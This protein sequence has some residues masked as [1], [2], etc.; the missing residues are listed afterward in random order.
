MFK[1]VIAEKPSVGI[2]IAN[3]L[4]ARKQKSGFYEGNGYIV[5]WCIGHL[6]GVSNAS[7]Y[8]P[9]Y[10]YWRYEHL[11]IIP[12]KWQN[13]LR[14]KTYQHFQLLKKTM[15]RKDV[16]EI[17]NACDAGREG[18]LIFR[19]AY[20]FAECNKPVKR[21]WISSMEDEAIRKG[22]ENLKPSEMYDNLYYS[23]DARAKADWLVGINFTRLFSVLYH[24]KLC[25]GRV[26]TPT[27]ALIISREA[28][29]TGFVP[30]TYYNAQITFG[31]LKATSKKISD[32]AE[33]EKIVAECSN[34]FATVISVN[35]EEKEEKAPLLY[36]LTTLQRD[37]N[38]IFGY[39]AQQ[40]LDYAQSLYEK[41]LCTYPRTDSRYLTEDMENT[42]EA[43]LK[44]SARLTSNDL[45]AHKYT[46]NKVCD[47][48]KVSDHH[49]II[50]TFTADKVDLF[51][52]NKEERNILRMIAL[53]LIC[54][55]AE[56]YVYCSKTAVLCCGNTEFEVKYR[57]I[58]KC[59]W[60]AF[61]KADGKGENGDEII[62]TNI[63]IGDIYE[64]NK[65]EVKKSKTK[66]KPHYTEDTLLSA[67]ENAGAAEALKDAE[68]KGLGTP[69]TRA[70]MIEKLVSAGYIERKQ[71]K[72][73][74]VLVPAK[75]GESLIFVVPEHIQS[76]LLT[77]EWEYRLKLIEKGELDADLFL[78]DIADMVT[79][80]CKNY[81]ISPD[82]D[83]LFPSGKE[84]V[85]TCPRCGGNVT[86]SKLGF[87]CE[88]LKCRFGLWRDNHF[89]KNHHI[90]L[91][92]DIARTLLDE[93]QCKINNIYLPK[94][95]K[96]YVGTVFFVD[97]GLKINFFVEY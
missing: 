96:T 11:P 9:D 50:P 25:I 88:N 76:P 84:V 82:A 56:P 36:D 63:D 73:G 5:A 23:A 37:A 75:I 93:G 38:R 95:G 77:A 19:N 54:S 51:D 6:A 57:N 30:E 32:K 33:A 14:K 78:S 94:T 70:N 10:A 47:N 62:E 4:G 59:G 60:A 61:I 34:Q 21:L 1:L 52:L 91:D 86:E 64:V 97:S 92:K 80:V 87:F 28:E 44:V 22:F 71:G 81:V 12:D 35:G 65:V 8:N 18:E 29:R 72:K 55:V 15:H 66:P 90:V 67:M 42:V 26:V 3:V 40:T 58:I 46:A 48:R 27:L 69:T 83:K 79:D 43:L 85:G 24:R 13:S 49:A 39:T 17:I 45:K 68:R 89:F 41:K 7:A 53:R 74:A 16:S 20:N 2:A 31:K